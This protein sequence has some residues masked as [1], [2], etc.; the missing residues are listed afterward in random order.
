MYKFSSSILL[1]M[2]HKYSVS[3]CTISKSSTT[4][5]NIISANSTSL[6]KTYAMDPQ[7]FKW[8]RSHLKIPGARRVTCTK[9]HTDDLPYKIYLPRIFT[10]LPKALMKVSS[11]MG[12]LSFKQYNPAKRNGIGRKS[13]VIYSH[14]CKT[15]NT[16]DIAEQLSQ[17]RIMRCSGVRMTLTEPLLNT[18]AHYK[19]NYYAVIVE[20]LHSKQ[21]ISLDSHENYRMAF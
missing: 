21:Y 1:I 14:V 3:K 8:S 9:F 13:I 4:L 7:I 20:N 2:A 17:H 6:L 18:I 19:D 12:R 11:F 10:T 16:F 15:D 5:R